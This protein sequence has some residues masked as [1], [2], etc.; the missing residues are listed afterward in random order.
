MKRHTNIGAEILS[1]SDAES[2]RMGEAIAISHHERWDG[3]G[4][5]Y[6]LKGNEIPIAGR[7]TAVAD[8]FDALTYKRPYKEALSIEASLNIIKRWK[9]KPF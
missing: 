4:Y 7:I 3:N 8:A 5:P 1:G 6:G 2:I 9:R